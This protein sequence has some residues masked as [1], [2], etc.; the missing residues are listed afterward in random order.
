MAETYPDY[1]AF[2]EGLVL[3]MGQEHPGWTRL[4]DRR[5]GEPSPSTR[6]KRAAVVIHGD[7]KYAVD[8][9]AVIENLLAPY[10]AWKAGQVDYP[11]VVGETRNKRPM[12]VPA[13]GAGVKTGFF[14]Y[15]QGAVK[16]ATQPPITVTIELPPGKDLGPGE[17][18]ELIMM[19]TQ[20][21]KRDA[22]FRARILKRWGGRCALTGCQDE[23]VLDAALIDAHSKSGDNRATNGILIRSDLHRLLD[24]ELLSL[25]MTG[26]VLTVAVA[27]E[28]RTPEYRALDGLKVTMPR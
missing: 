3:P 1:V 20:R 25:D 5:A 19:A 17:I 4:D 2:I 9:D 28:V 13:P 23:A 26:K 18:S 22:A 16:G 24:R 11:V 8:D 12:L 21:A 15:W 7:Q 14:I 10:H 6:A 27:P